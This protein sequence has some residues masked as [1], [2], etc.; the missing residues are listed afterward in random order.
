MPDAV[1]AGGGDP[2]QAGAREERHHQG[3]VVG[4]APGECGGRYMDRAARARTRTHTHRLFTHSRA[5]LGC[6]T[7]VGR[8]TVTNG[9][10]YRSHTDIINARME[11]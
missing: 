8:A 6:E 3:N 5:T 10:H 1:G 4:E 9:R 11:A 7:D 2:V